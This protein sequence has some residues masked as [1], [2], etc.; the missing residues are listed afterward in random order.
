MA[1]EDSVAGVR[2]ARAMGFLTIL[3]GKAQPHEAMEADS[4]VEHFS[5]LTPDRL[6]T[7]V[8]HAEKGVR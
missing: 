7:I 8:G 3:V 5:A 1:I 6:R 4:W 2:T